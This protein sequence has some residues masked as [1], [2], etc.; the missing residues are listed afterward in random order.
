MARVR[1]GIR[2]GSLRDS[3]GHRTL[4]R[5]QSS[6]EVGEGTLGRETDAAGGSH[7]EDRRD[8]LERRRKPRG[9]LTAGEG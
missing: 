7:N 4:P 2:E 9:G 6:G 5:G 1:M 3:P 8:P